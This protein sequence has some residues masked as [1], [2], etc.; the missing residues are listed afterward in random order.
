MST[1]PQP[2]TT[3]NVDG[4]EIETLVDQ[5]SSSLTDSVCYFLSIELFYSFIFFDFSLKNLP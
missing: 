5:S 2:T 3:T 1:L 4:E